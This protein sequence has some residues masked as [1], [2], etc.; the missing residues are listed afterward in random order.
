MAGAIAILKDSIFDLQL[1]FESLS[2]CPFNFKGLLTTV[3]QASSRF[4]L[5]ENLQ[6]A[7]QMMAGA[8]ETPAPV[9]PCSTGPT[10]VL[11]CACPIMNA[12]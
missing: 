11:E 2:V 8:Q 1:G 9:E 6:L 4:D 3:E 5:A 10:R 12:C 7:W